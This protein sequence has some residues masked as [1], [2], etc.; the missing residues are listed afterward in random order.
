MFGF[1]T[2]L[3]FPGKTCLHYIEEFTKVKMS[4]SVDVVI[5]FVNSCADHFSAITN[6]HQP[7]YD[8]D[9]F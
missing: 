8:S 5:S 1:I 6:I 2:R 9:Y 4:W 7:V 3:Y